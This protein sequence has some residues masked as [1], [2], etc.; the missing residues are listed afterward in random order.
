MKLNVGNAL[1]AGDIRG[2]VTLP[3]A[4]NIS[5]ITINARIH[6]FTSNDSTFRPNNDDVARAL[7]KTA[8]DLEPF[9]AGVA[10]VVLVERLPLGM[11]RQASKA[12]RAQLAGCP[13]SFKFLFVCQYFN[14]LFT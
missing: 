11:R 3:S 4:A 2:N 8:H 1:A 13:P 10:V 5:P 14:V 7:V 6:Y 12:G 9:A